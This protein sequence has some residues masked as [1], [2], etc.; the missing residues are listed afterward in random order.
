[1][2]KFSWPINDSRTVKKDNIFLTIKGRNND[3]VR[4]YVSEALEKGSKIYC[5]FKKYQKT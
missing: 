2:K 4:I 5:F 3:G 1:M